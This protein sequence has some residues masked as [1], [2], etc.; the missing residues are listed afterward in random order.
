MAGPQDGAL[1]QALEELK[2]ERENTAIITS[3]RVPYSTRPATFGEAAHYKPPRSV[4]TTYVKQRPR[5]SLFFAI[6]AHGRA[7]KISLSL[8]RTGGGEAERLPYL[9]LLTLTLPARL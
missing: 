8:S 5:S 1:S 7:N 9:T 3:L 4:L 2:E 6:D